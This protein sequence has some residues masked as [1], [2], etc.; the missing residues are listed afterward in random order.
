MQKLIFGLLITL[1]GVQFSF[2]QDAST[3]KQLKDLSQSK[4]QWMAD[5]NV[6]KLAVLFDDRAKFVHMSGSWKKARELEIIETGSI[7]YKK[8][9]V[10]D[11]AVEVFGNTA[12][13][14]SRITLD[15]VVRTN[16]VSTEFTVTE[17]FQ[18]Q[19]SDWKLLDLTFSSVR[20]THEI[21]K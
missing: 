16:E 14:W 21:E 10:H 6:D 9:T 7:W 20:D 5:K 3:E 1:L 12:I 4:W 2:A 13:V 15:A 17:I 11:V 18:K 19:S 8:A